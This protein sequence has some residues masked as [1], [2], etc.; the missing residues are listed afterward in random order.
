MRLV[1]MFLIACAVAGAQEYS[2]VT[3]VLDDNASA[4]EKRYAGIF[5]RR[6]NKFSKATVTVGQPAK[7]PGEIVVHLGVIENRSDIA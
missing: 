6:V 3:V 4:M 2:R 5:A 1:L 7:K